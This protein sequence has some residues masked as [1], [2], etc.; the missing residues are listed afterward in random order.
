MHRV[1][2]LCGAE[3]DEGSLGHIALHQDDLPVLVQVT[4]KAKAKVKVKDPLGP[5]GTLQP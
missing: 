3:V 5:Q 2:G 4:V 1:G